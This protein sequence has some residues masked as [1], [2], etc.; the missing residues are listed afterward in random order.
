MGVHLHA[1]GGPVEG[2]QEE[3]QAGA[4][5]PRHSGESLLGRVPASSGLCEH[6]RPGH[7]ESV[8]DSE[9]SGEVV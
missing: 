1:G 4:K 2:G 3:G 6:D 8:Q 9:H 5:D 7:Q